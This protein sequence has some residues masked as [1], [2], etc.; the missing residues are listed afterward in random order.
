MK[1]SDPAFIPRTV[2]KWLNDPFLDMDLGKAIINEMSQYT[3]II[4]PE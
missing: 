1:E 3:D 2:L 4:I